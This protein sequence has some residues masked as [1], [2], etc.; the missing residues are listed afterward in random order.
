MFSFLRNLHAFLH[1]VCTNLYSHQQVRG[2]SFSIPSPLLIIC[3]LFSGVHSD[4]CEL[5]PHCGLNLHFSS[6]VMMNIFLSWPL[7]YLCV[8]IEETCV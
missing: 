4:W 1:S 3:R 7:G 5:V 8:L 6:S 2:F